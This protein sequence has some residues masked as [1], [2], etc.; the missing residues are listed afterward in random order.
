[1]HLK[2]DRGRGEFVECLFN[3]S[4]FVPDDLAQCLSCVL[5]ATYCAFGLRLGAGALEQP[6]TRRIVWRSYAFPFSRRRKKGVFEKTLSLSAEK[7]FADE[8]TWIT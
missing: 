6:T 4:T 7:I 5:F 2:E 8:I 3:T 1:V